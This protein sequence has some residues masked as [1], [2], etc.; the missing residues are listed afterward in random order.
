MAGIRFRSKSRL[1]CIGT[2]D[3]NPSRLPFQ[4]VLPALHAM[5]ACPGG[6]T[7]NRRGTGTRKPLRHNACTFI[8]I[9]IAGSYVFY[10]TSVFFD[11][12]IET[13]CLRHA[14]V[15]P[16]SRSSVGWAVPANRIPDPQP[17]WHVATR[18]VGTTR[19]LLLP[20][21]RGFHDP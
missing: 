1:N 8:K 16:A 17:E 19:K 12:L 13:D 21:A 2:T 14:G 15:N 20:N 7:G 4:P 6:G 10:Q 11:G 18:G 3:G 5:A 9:A